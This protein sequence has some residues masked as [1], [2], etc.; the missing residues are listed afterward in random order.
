MRNWKDP[1]LR[2][3]IERAGV[4]SPAGE[5]QAR[6]LRAQELLVDLEDELLAAARLADA[7]GWTA[8]VRCLDGMEEGVG[9]ELEDGAQAVPEAL[10]ADLA[11]PDDRLLARLARRTISLGG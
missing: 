8:V 3:R 6:L 4:S 7:H 11:S 9:C 2:E 10:L 5:L 1:E